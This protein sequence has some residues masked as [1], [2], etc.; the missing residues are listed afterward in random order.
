LA[1]GVE[2]VIQQNKAQGVFGV[3][4][5]SVAVSENAGTISINYYAGGF[6]FLIVLV[7]LVKLCQR[8]PTPEEQPLYEPLF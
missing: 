2:G 5:T 6:C 7:F 8:K 1:E 4:R 3:R